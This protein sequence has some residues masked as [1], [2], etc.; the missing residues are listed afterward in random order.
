MTDGPAGRPN[1]EELARRV[2]E[3][4]AENHRLRALLG[5][6]AEGRAAAAPAWE[7]TLFPQA[8]WPSSAVTRRSS[9]T[10]K[11][12]LFMSLFRG[13]DDTHALRWDNPRSGKSGWGPAVEGGWANIRRPDRQLLPFT[14]TVV[15]DHLEGRVH[16]GLYPLRLDDSCVLL[17]CDFDGPG[18]TLDALAYLDAAREL[19]Y[20]NR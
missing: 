4:E 13:R 15:H 16:A 1:A 20:R 3:L 7:P 12:Q 9:P 6:G 19:A 18:W 10:E 2:A 11:V 14:D 8:P 5:P 17:A